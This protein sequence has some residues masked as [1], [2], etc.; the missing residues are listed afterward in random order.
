MRV[1]FMALTGLC[2]VYCAVL[3]DFALSR[4]QLP[5]IISSQ[6]LGSLNKQQTLGEVNLESLC[7]L[8]LVVCYALLSSSL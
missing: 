7:W 8:L 6:H 1:G 4:T 5:L 2:C 3:S